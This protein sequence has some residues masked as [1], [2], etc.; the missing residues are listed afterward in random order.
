MKCKV[1][2]K[3]EACGGG[4]ATSLHD[5]NVAGVTSPVPRAARSA[6][7]RSPPGSSPPPSSSP[8]TVEAAT[9]AVT[10]HSSFSGRSASSQENVS[11]SKT[12]PVII[13]CRG[14]P[15]KTLRCLAMIDEHS[16]HCF[17]DESVLDRF[18]ISAPYCEYNL[19]TLAG[20]KLR[21]QGKA[22]TGLQVKGLRSKKWHNIPEALTGGHMPDSRAERATRPV[23]ECIPSLA[24]LAH[25]F[26]EED[27]SLQTLLIIGRTMSNV[28]RVRSFGRRPP[29]AHQNILGWSVVCEY[30][31][32]ALPPHTLAARATA[33]TD[34]RAYRGVVSDVIKSAKFRFLDRHEQLTP[35]SDIFEV[36]K[37]DDVLTWSQN[38][39][40]FMSILKDGTER[41]ADGRLQLPLPLKARSHPIP[42]NEVPVYCR[43]RSTLQR[44]CKD[45]WTLKKVR[46]AMRQYISLKHVERVPG[47]VPR[48][49]LQQLWWIL[50]L[51]L[52]V[53]EKKD[54][55]RITLDGSA[56]YQG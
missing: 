11:F 26:E 40:Q 8:S 13:R 14:D 30:P 19:E 10:S 50:P 18:E 7:P 22:V 32:A 35:S 24:H 21:R 34:T 45:E 2:V 1:Q 15:R 4:H 51:V 23:V 42:N 38:D 44:A 12:Q 9:G 31:R 48:S 55:I 36:R 49:D 27:E 46:E 33:V 20:L 6:T 16:D 52:V 5:L 37:D 17:V 39:E 54:N 56:T 25:N 43:N 29:F 53:Q 3:C 28:F 47:T 41:V